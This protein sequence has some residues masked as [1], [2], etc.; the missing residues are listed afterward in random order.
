MNHTILGI[1][2]T[3]RVRRAEQVQKALTEFGGQIRT[4]IGLHDPS[5]DYRSQSG[6]ILLEVVGP[7]A[8]LNAMVKRLKAVPG[9]DVKKMVF[10]H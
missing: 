1:H 2:V 3:N 5:E 4:R 6:L 8:K 7:A 10:A 9:V